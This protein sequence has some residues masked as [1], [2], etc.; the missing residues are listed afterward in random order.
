MDPEDLHSENGSATRSLL[1]DYDET[2]ANTTTGVI[3][4][5]PFLEPIISSSSS[6][7]GSSAAFIGDADATAINR[8]T[9]PK[10]ISTMTY[11]LVT[12][13]LL[14]ICLFLASVFMP[15]TTGHDDDNILLPSSSPT[16]SSSGQ[17]EQQQKYQ[18]ENGNNHSSD[19]MVRQN[20]PTGIHISLT[21]NV[22]EMYVQFATGDSGEP[23]VEF[24]KQNT[25]V[26]R[27]TTITSS[28]S[29]SW[30][31]VKG[32]STTYAATDMCQEPATLVSGFDSPGHLHTVKLYNL[33][34]NTEYMYRVG[35]GFGQ[36]VKWSEETYRFRTS[37]PPG[38]GGD[39]STVPAVTFLAFGDQGY[40]D[41]E[42]HGSQQVAQLITSI[43]NEQTIDS[44][45]HI[46][47]LCYA[48]GVSH[49]WN[50]WLNMIQPY[51]SQVPY[52]V[53]NGNHEYDHIAGGSGGKDPSGE[54]TEF[55]F[56][57]DWGETSFHSTGGEC[58]VPI[59][60]RFA[61]P[62]NGNSVFWYVSFSEAL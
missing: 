57:P 49:I 41:S 38:G 60:K 28:S 40:S 42:S 20:E 32:T 62:D 11:I 19:K 13:V 56:Q 37:N 24:T 45:H 30:I 4:S 2:N 6:S 46:G 27:T 18:Q 55:G 58:G 44:I 39:E 59:S 34:P 3:S 53:A 51:A 52:M 15:Q 50:A 9:K 54:V 48:N 25:H 10:T 5:S 23:I 17:Q 29:T 14:M 16:S 31:K 26:I 35:L 47:D 1:Y 33:E 8:K 21:G 7:F 22:T 43:I 36:G 61:T 12:M